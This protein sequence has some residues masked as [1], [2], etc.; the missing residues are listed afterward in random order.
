VTISDVEDFIRGSAS[1]AMNNH[2]GLNTMSAA[3]ELAR[4]GGKNGAIGIL[5]GW[6]I[7]D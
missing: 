1:L 3:D 5:I 2:L 6:L 4:A 7:S